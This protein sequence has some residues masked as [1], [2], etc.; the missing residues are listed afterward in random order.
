MRGSPVLAAQPEC[1]ST[2]MKAEV[3]FDRRQAAFPQPRDAWSDELRCGVL[4]DV[5]FGPAADHNHYRAQPVAFSFCARNAGILY[6]QD[7]LVVLWER[8]AR[9]VG[10]LASALQMDIG[11]LSPM[12]KRLEAKGL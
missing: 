7:V 2:S 6:A 10:D 1:N 3:I 8:G 9:G 12:L 4:S 11:S 5:S